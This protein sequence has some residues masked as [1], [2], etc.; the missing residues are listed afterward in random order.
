MRQWL[1]V[2]VHTI[3]TYTSTN[4][5]HTH[6]PQRVL[7]GKMMTNLCKWHKKYIFHP[8]AFQSRLLL[9]FKL[10]LCIKIVVIFFF[11]GFFLLLLLLTRCIYFKIF[12]ETHKKN[13]YKRALCVCLKL[14]IYLVLPAYFHLSPLIRLG[15]SYCINVC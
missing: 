15:P 2:F 10:C 1:S 6:S 9:I 8:V 12:R 5:R 3:R 4:T 11:L 7:G 14:I 13:V